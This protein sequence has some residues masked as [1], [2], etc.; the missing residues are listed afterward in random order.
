MAAQ[1]AAITD[2]GDTRRREL[3]QQL[4]ADPPRWAVEAFGP[5][6]AHAGERGEW[7]DRAATVAAHRE[8]VEHT[9]QVDV[10][11]PV[12]KPGQI[13]TYASWRAAARALGRDDAG[14]AEEGM[15]DGQLRMRI[16]A[17]D[18][19]QTWAP[20]R[21]TDELAGTIQAAEHHRAN[22]ELA[23]ARAAAASDPTERERLT[24]EARGSGACAGLLEERVEVLRGLDHTYYDWWVHTLLTRH[25]AERAHVEL[26]DRGTLHAPD[27]E[28]VT[29]AEW[30]AA[31][32]EAD[33]AEDPHREIT[34]H[35]LDITDEDPAQELEPTDQGELID[36]AAVEQAKEHVQPADTLD[37]REITA[38][39]RS[40][41]DENIVRVPNADETTES[42]DRATRALAELNAR[43]SL[44]NTRTAEEERAAQLARWHH[45]DRTA[46]Y[47]VAAERD[48]P[49]MDLGY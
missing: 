24:Q 23:T 43:L 49:G 25:A 3:G 9:D 14:T 42:V 6:P 11:G 5:V 35:D 12:P 38:H 32:A 1:L 31:R 44:D 41:E 36:R 33:A 28:R 48:D 8:L 16:R 20:R 29:A 34:E 2:T 13:E 22:T 18:R 40:R 21:V 7:I 46:E 19:E 4:A 30:H 45:D 15:S 17:W 10:L 47:A 37:L 39:E 26:G 27:H